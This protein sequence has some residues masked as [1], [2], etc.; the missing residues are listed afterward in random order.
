MFFICSQPVPARVLLI[1]S[2][3]TFFLFPRNAS[4]TA[5]LPEGICLVGNGIRSAPMYSLNTSMCIGLGISEPKKPTSRGG[6]A[7]WL[8]VVGTRRTLAA[9]DVTAGSANNLC[10]AHSF[11]SLSATGSHSSILTGSD[12][13]QYTWIPR[14]E[15]IN[16]GVGKSNSLQNLR[17]AIIASFWFA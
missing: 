12:K 6:S 7:L 2:R 14:P 11:F 16:S 8:W 1:I 3:N 10:F 5:L 17:N 13:N 9:S 15:L 4:I